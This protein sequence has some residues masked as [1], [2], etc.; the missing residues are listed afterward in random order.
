MCAVG[1]APLRWT[2]GRALLG[3][4]PRILITAIQSKLFLFSPSSANLRWGLPLRLHVL[5]VAAL[6]GSVHVELMAVS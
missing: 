3:R 6:I 1:Y 4:L 2:V 5:V